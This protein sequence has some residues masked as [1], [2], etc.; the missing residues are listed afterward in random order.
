MNNP[1]HRHEMPLGVLFLGCCN[2]Q[3]ASLNHTFLATTARMML[4][5]VVIA[6]GTRNTNHKVAVG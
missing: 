6:T 3:E 2:N 4:S 5:A 1:R